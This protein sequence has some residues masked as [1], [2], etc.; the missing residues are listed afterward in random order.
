[1][2]SKYT[3]VSIMAIALPVALVLGACTGGTTGSTAPST[4]VAAGSLSASRAPTPEPT[5]SPPASA[6][7][8]GGSATPG[9]VDPCSLLTKEEASTLMGKTLS[10]GVSTTLDPG[11]VCTFK[12]GLSEVRLILA[13][14]AP[15]AATAQ[16]YWDAQRAEVPAGM[17]ITDVTGFDRAAYGSASLSGQ[18]LSALFVISG[19]FFFD[20]YCGFP[21]CSQD[22]SVTAAQLIVGR[23]P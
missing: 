2:S 13:P 4:I 1:M 8:A 15:D 23:L 3:P 21:A 9:N 6:E 5:A 10:A 16:A 7:V 22:A 17:T 20:L 19:T 18:S 11:R 14:Q 12:S